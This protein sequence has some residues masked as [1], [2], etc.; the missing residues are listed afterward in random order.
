MVRLV[1][2]NFL[3]EPVR[4]AGTGD[5]VEWLGFRTAEE[6]VILHRMSALL[7]HPSHIDNSP[8]SVAEAMGQGYPLSHP[9]SAVFL[10]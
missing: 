1:I 10:R 4:T 9:M 7:I 2:S 5:H 6:I 3:K 8:N